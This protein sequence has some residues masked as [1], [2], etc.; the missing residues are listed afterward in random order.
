MGLLNSTI[1]DVGIGLVFIYLLLAIICTTS[2]EW[3][4]GWLGL[5]SKT[6]ANAIRQLLDQQKGSGDPTRSFLE[7]FYS[8]PLISGMMT[9]GGAH[10]SYLPSRTF[11]AAVMDIATIRKPGVISFADLDAGIK[12][13]P[14]GDVKTALS[15]LIQNVPNDLNRA[16]KNIE[17]WFDDTM[18]RASGWYK[19]RTQLVTILIAVLLAAATNA[20]TVKITRTLW[21]SPTLR[22]ALVEKAKNRTESP[23]S[24]VEYNDK[25]NPLKPSIKPTKDE[26]DALQVV[27]GWSDAEWRGSDGKAWLERVLGW[28]LT[29][30]A[31]SLG[32]PFWFDLLGKFMNMR[33]AGKKPET[34]DKQAKPQTA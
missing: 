28:I 15:A 22:V 32:A 6:L 27:L 12:D 14:D 33:N 9:P 24:A 25:N 11:A 34:S 30:V 3:I 31:V 5:R 13:L 16:Q 18:D 19:R 7:Q 29:I 8:H 26:L 21:K 2:N 10:P 1:L 4:V 20:D 23:Q 17:Q